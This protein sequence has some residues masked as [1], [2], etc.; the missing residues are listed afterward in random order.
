MVERMRDC[1]CD[2]ARDD[3]R[4]V[5]VARHVAV[6]ATRVRMRLLLVR[7]D[8]RRVYRNSSHC[9]PCNRRANTADEP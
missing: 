6:D 9:P 4:L 1:I 8:G 3:V 7:V 5:L 2:A